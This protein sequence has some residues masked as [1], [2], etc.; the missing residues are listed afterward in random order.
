MPTRGRFAQGDNQGFAE[1]P[2]TTSPLLPG[3]LKSKKPSLQEITEQMSQVPSTDKIESLSASDQDPSRGYEAVKS[4]MKPESQ[5]GPK[6]HKEKARMK[7]AYS[8]R[9]Y[10]SIIMSGI[11]PGNHIKSIM[12]NQK[13]D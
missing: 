11:P 9:V 12:H 5:F 2:A 13:I 8:P 7:A 4:E 3:L 6:Q 1:S 10:L